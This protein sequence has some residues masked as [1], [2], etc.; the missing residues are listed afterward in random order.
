MRP[1]PTIEEYLWN[2]AHSLFNFKLLLKK[3]FMKAHDSLKETIHSIWTDELSRVNNNNAL[4]PQGIVD[5]SKISILENT[6]PRWTIKDLAIELWVKYSLLPSLSFSLSI[7]QTIQIV[8]SIILRQM[9]R[10]W[11]PNAIPLYPYPEVILN[12]T[13]NP[14]SLHRILLYWGLGAV[15]TVFLPSDQKG[16]DMQ[17][18]IK[19][20]RK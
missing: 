19:I 20:G 2:C 15:R 8:N 16:E 9:G 4:L 7:S 6:R 14:S 12:N 1:F 10:E 18:Q 13:R 17:C 3:S 11:W 5:R